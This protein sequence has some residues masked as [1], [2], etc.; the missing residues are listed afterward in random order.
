[1]HRMSTSA[2]IGILIRTKA[3]ITVVVTRSYLDDMLFDSVQ[4]CNNIG[5]CSAL[6]L[7]K[8]LGDYLLVDQE[9]SAMIKSLELEK[10]IASAVHR[11]RVIVTG[12]AICIHMHDLLHKL[13][14]TNVR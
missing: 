13:S 11:C 7:Q 14:F 8:C 9:L 12:P 4:I 3:C 6:S 10:E 5:Q 1:M 2:Y